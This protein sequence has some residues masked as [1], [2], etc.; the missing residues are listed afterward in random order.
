MLFWLIVL[1]SFYVAFYTLTFAKVVWQKEKNLVA[2]FI[3]CI[4]GLSLPVLSIWI[5]FNP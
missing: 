3:I 1:L 4:L 5:K 2:T